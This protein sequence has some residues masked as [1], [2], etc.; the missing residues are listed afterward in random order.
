[1]GVYIVK[2]GNIVEDVGVVLEGS[3]VLEG[4]DNVALATAL[5]FG[6]VYALNLSY[7]ASL[8]YTFEVIQKVFMQ[9]DTGKLS[10]KAL[11]R[12]P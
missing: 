9:L 5:L 1:M 6:L 2:K 11:F 3:V 4:I 10:N 7:P 12:L 8:R